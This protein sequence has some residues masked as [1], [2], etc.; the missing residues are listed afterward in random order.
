MTDVN[1][2]KFTG[3]NLT[4]TAPPSK[5]YTHRALIAAALAEGDSEI[6][7]PLYSEDTAITRTALCGMGVRIGRSPSGI[8]VKG[9]SGRLTCTDPLLDM[10]SSGTSMRLLLPVAALC[11]RPV[12]LTGS[13]RMRERPLG[14]LVDGLNRLGASVEYTEKKGYPPV[15]TGGTLKGGQVTMN[16]RI[17][18]QFISS[19]LLAAPC[20]SRDVEVSVSGEPVSR[21]YIDITIDIMAAFGVRVEREGYRSFRIPGG[22]PYRGRVY[23]IEGDY[24]SASYFF[25]IAA[26]S[27]GMVSVEGINPVSVQGDRMFLKALKKMGCEVAASDDRVT[28][29][30]NGQPRGV[31]IDMSSSPDTVQTLCMVAALAGSPSRISGITHLRWKETDRI[32]ST[33][34]LLRSLGGDVSADSDSIT[35]RPAPLHGGIIDPG[36]DHRT[37]MS[38]AILGLAVGGVTVKNA[39]CVAK[40]FPGFWKSIREAGLC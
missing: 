6:E 10:G 27:G 18:S 11:G 21:A 5:S 30:C 34:N 36:D 19:I 4:F 26:C 15:I 24:S 32:S 23:R 9:T 40:S 16:G 28:V 38:F 25:A 1:V 17:S 3:G 35:I 37:A 39:E 22:V 33:V 12:T 2:P 8:C 7:S 20:A 29:V 14:P 31:D 13:P